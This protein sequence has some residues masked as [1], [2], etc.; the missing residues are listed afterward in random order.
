MSTTPTHADTRNFL[1]TVLFCRQKS[2]ALTHR[3][4]SCV[5]LV[6]KWTEF[7]TRSVIN[8][9]VQ[10]LNYGHGIKLGVDAVIKTRK[11]PKKTTHH[12]HHHY[13]EE[14]EVLYAA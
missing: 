11:H 3:V 14:E 5:V 8:I 13:D 9:G 2:N 4:E 7:A 6:R 12:H 1:S 10:P